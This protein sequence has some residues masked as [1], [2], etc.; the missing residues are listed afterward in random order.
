MFAIFQELSGLQLP[1]QS[2]KLERCGWPN[3]S[4]GACVSH[5][6]GGICEEPGNCLLLL[7]GTKLSKPR[8]TINLAAHKSQQKNVYVINLHHGSSVYL[9]VHTLSLLEACE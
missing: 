1:S 8:E 7:L 3:L 2:S 9:C 4:P 5:W 6:P